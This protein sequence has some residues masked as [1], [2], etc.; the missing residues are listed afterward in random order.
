MGK[1]SLRIWELI[2]PIVR[3]FILVL[4]IAPTLSHSLLFSQYSYRV[5]ISPVD[6]K[7]VFLLLVVISLIGCATTG[8]LTYSDEDLA[9][10]KEAVVLM[11][12]MALLSAVES[13][14][15]QFVLTPVNA[16]PTTFEPLLIAQN[17]VPGLTRL[18][19]EYL[20]AMREDVLEIVA[21]IPH[22]FETAL[23]PN[24]KIATPYSLI[25]GN[26]DAV[27]RYFASSFSFESEKWLTE[28]I[29]G[30]QRGMEAWNRLIRTY[31]NYL[32]GKGRLTK[33][34]VVLL[35]GDPI[36]EITV[37]LIRHIVEAM[38]RQEAL[39]RSLAPTYE[40]PLILLFSR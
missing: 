28:Q 35:E 2:G 21:K 8:E 29:S 22:Q 10:G 40:E 27:T 4:D 7:I 39:I 16:L 32:Q 13:F 30:G 37:A 18:L 20:E 19:D 11:S 3:L 5:I 34:E 25:K 17:E 9:L 33:S 38:A 26:N 6:K 12:Q 31:N 1:E 36:K 23:L 14:S 15:T 24:I